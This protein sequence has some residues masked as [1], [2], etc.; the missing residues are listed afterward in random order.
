M[1]LW[2]CDANLL[3][4]QVEPTNYEITL[5]S[6]SRQTRSRRPNCGVRRRRMPRPV[7]AKTT[8]T[9]KPAPG[10]LTLLA[11]VAGHCDAQAPPL[12]LEELNAVFLLLRQH[13]PLLQSRQSRRVSRRSVDLDDPHEYKCP[14][15]ESLYLSLFTETRRPPAA[16]R[17]SS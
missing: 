1:T 13:H 4:R 7:A 9:S 15:C 3:Q 8:S 16:L 17:N 12:V 11:D 6:L 5:I 10:R 14:Q 2:G